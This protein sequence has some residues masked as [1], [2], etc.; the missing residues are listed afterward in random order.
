M[1][2][3]RA[4]TIN[5]FALANHAYREIF[6]SRHSGDP[7]IP[8]CEPWHLSIG[9]R[10]HGHR[11]VTPP[12]RYPGAHHLLLRELRYRLDQDGREIPG[13]AIYA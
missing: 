12:A 2:G 5:A 4:P 1:S 8:S 13:T 7:T 3:D 6:A 9:E 11:A 10:W